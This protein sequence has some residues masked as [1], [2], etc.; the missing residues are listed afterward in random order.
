M[1]DPAALK[2]ELQTDPTALGYAPHIASGNDVALVEML[3]AARAGIDIRRD[4][5]P[6]H[7]LFEAIVPADWTA[8][9]AQEKQRIQLVLSMGT[10]DVRGANTRAAFQAAFGAGTTTRANLLA[11]LTRPGSRAEALF[12][13]P[14]SIDDL[15][16]ARLT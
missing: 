13:E 16:K 9:T 15:V 8:A 12:G 14:V 5:I 11:L 6:S 4:L 10:V 7:E 2:A 1:I 3:N